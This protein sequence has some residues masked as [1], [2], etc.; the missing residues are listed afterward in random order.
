M[1]RV[2]ATCQLRI[3]RFRH[4]VQ[5]VRLM[6]PVGASTTRVPTPWL[7]SAARASTPWLSCM[8]ALRHEGVAHPHLDG[9]H[10][11]LCLQGGCLIGCTSHDNRLMICEN[12]LRYAKGL[13]I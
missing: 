3:V 6:Y 10:L 9:F 4:S 5:N 7:I 13:R 1:A 12:L 11:R 8:G 2:S